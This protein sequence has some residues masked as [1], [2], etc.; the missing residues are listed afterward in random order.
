[1]IKAEVKNRRTFTIN[2]T[3]E[4]ETIETKVERIVSN[5]EPITDG[6]PLYFTERKDG[7]R[8]EFDI[9]TDK[10]QIAQ[11]AMDMKSNGQ[12][13][14]SEER[15]QQTQQAVEPSQG[16]DGDTAA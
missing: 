14:E 15:D 2:E 7:V 13:R 9:R 8:P 1:M 12:V 16:G 3:V 6:A 10:W 5:R 4:G 11:R